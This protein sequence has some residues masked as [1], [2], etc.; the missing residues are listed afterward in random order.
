M[1]GPPKWRRISH[2]SWPEKAPLW[3]LV[4]VVVAILLF[5]PS[6]KRYY[7]VSRRWRRTLENEKEKKKEIEQ[8]GSLIWRSNLL[9][10]LANN[11]RAQVERAARLCEPFTS[12]IALGSSKE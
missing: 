11:K 4:V 7:C 5:A 2:E 3:L 12:E 1:K 10:P 9:T 6:A 8:S